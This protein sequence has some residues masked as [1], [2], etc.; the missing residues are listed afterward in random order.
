MRALGIGFA[1]VL[2]LAATA[3]AAFAAPKDSISPDERKAGMKAA[4]ALIDAA[5]L[6]CTLTDARLMG[7]GAG[8]DKVKTTFYEIACQQGMGYVLGAKDKVPAPA[9][10]DCVMMSTPGPDGKPNPSACKLPANL[11]P[12]AGL[13]PIMAK[14][15]RN[16]AV[17]KARY[18]GSTPDM[19]LTEYEVT[20]GG[21]DYILQSPS[22]PGSVPTVALCATLPP[23][24]GAQC[25]LTTPEQQAA[26]YQQLVTASGKACT[27]KDKRYIGATADHVDYFEV[28]CTEGKG[29]ILE[30]DASGA[31][32]E[33][34]DC[35]KAMNIGGGCTLTDARQAETEQDAIYTDLAKKAGFDCSVS[36]Y[37]EFPAS[38]SG[39]EVVELACSNRP[40]GGV[41]F[42]SA[43][44]P[45]VVKDCLRAEAEGYR[46]SF[47][48]ADAL[49]SKLTAQLKAKGKPSCIVNGARAYGRTTT[50]AELVEVACNDGGPGWVLEY[51][52]D[53]S[54]PNDLLNCAQAAAT[55]GGG[56]QLPTNK[57]H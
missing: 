24:S 15:G 39:A 48:P 13:T 25:T 30:S 6:N 55:G 35:A 49:Y 36:K 43:K 7:S 28:A 1:A 34:V 19:S 47:S 23:G 38:E 50:G 3:S 5:H 14:G 10:Y 9:V 52:A 12:A 32:K 51:A 33:A 46:C 11:N 17:D 57:S 40:D 8:P 37:A 56:C 16:C 26:V 27:I 18:L 22:A 44:G 21:G 31:F 20:C 54:V 41:G 4:P 45:P 42:F 2:M 53:S 29:Y